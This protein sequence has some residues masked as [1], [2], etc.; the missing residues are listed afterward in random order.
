VIKIGQCIT[1]K[2]FFPP[3]FTILKERKGDKDLY[4]CYFCERGVTSVQGRKKDGQTFTY[5]RGE[6]I[7]D[8]K[9][10][11]KMIRETPGVAEALAKNKVKFELA[12]S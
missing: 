8:Y 9:K 4:N 6:C 3:E 2:E 12:N 1:C 10:F 7:K 5:T 11:V